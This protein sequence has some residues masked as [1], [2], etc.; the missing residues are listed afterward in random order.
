MPGPGIEPEPFGWEA[1][2]LPLSYIPPLNLDDE[3]F[4][5]KVAFITMRLIFF[6]NIRMPTFIFFLDKFIA[7]VIFATSCFYVSRKYPC[8][9]CQKLFWRVSDHLV[10]IHNCPRKEARNWSNW[11]RQEEGR[12]S[13]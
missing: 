5:G 3:L 6:V 7:V 11:K 12:V 2:A 13:L 8:P 4:R 1:E 10:S 9:M